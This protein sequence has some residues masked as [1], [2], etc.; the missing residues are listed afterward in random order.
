[1]FDA[2]ASRYDLTNDVMSLWQVRV[3]RAVTRAAVAARPGARVPDLAAGTGT[4]PAEYPS[5]IHLCPP[6]RPHHARMRWV[7]T[8]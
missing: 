2:V 7:S 4:S 5:L 6:R 8:H 3:W 1:M